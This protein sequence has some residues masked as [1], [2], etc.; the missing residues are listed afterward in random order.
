MNK[1]YVIDQDTYNEDQIY[2]ALNETGLFNQI[3][4]GMHVVIKPN[5][6]LDRHT[7]GDDSWEDIITN[8]II[9]QAV[10][11][12]VREKLNDSGIIS[13][14][15]SPVDTADFSEMKKIMDLDDEV[16]KCEKNGIQCEFIDL[17][18]LWHVRVHGGKAYIASKKLPSDPRGKVIVKIPEEFSEFCGFDYEGKDFHSILPDTRETNA[19]HK[20]GV[21]MYSVSKTCLQA[22][23]FINMPKLKVHKKAGITVS[24]KNLVGINTHKN[25]LPHYCTGSIA[26]GGDEYP[27]IDNKEKRNH[28]IVTFAKVILEKFKFLGY[29][30]PVYW[31]IGNKFLG[32]SKDI[33]RGGGWYGNDTL[34]RMILD[35]NKI[36]K[37]ADK[38][39]KISEKPAARRYITVVDGV[40]AGQGNG[41]S[42]CWPKHLGKIICGDNAVAVDYVCTKFMRFNA[43]YIKSVSNGFKIKKLKLIDDDKMIQIVN[44]NLCVNVEDFDFS[45]YEQ[46]DIPTCGWDVLELNHD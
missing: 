17:R 4:P 46:F 14:V 34:W 20:N 43:N 13:I 26:D 11:R 33:V 1:V 15:D 24:L 10:V 38:D 35:L 32:D 21:H 2:L 29:L 16:K 23:V 42:N 3:S 31:K 9:I 25:Y 12:I 22:D 36:I 18:D 7:N 41:P 8:P 30:A 5:M 37:Y 45:G 6:V 40:V 44:G 28:N 39:G 27:Y 19:A